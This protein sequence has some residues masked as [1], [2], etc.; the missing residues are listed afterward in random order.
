MAKRLRISHEEVH[1]LETVERA[2][3][4][5]LAELEKGP[6]PAHAIKRKLQV[7]AANP[8]EAALDGITGRSN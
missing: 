6:V 8:L 5:L 2:L 7:Y 1:H 4:E 3:A